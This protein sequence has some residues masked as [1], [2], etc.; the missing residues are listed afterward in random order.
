MHTPPLFSASSL[1]KAVGLLQEN[2]V[3]VY[4]NGYYSVAPEAANILV[5]EAVNLAA[6]TIDYEFYDIKPAV[7][8]EAAER[9]AGNG[10]YVY[11]DMDDDENTVW[12]MYHR[13]VG[14]IGFHDPYG[15]IT[16]LIDGKKVDYAPAFEWSGI[17][18]QDQAFDLL[19]DPDL[20]AKM[21]EHTKPEF[22]TPLIEEQL[23][24]VQKFGDDLS[25]MT[26]MDAMD[27]PTRQGFMAMVER[28]RSDKVAPTQSTQLPDEAGGS[29]VTAVSRGKKGMT[30]GA[31]PVTIF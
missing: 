11:R 16:L 3:E 1:Q 9:G 30:Q 21:A 27:E 19:K 6:K 14:A 20:V 7:F 18:R 4:G 5:A 17:Y 2:G 10:V 23:K 13:D 31:K 12:R 22:M 8:V 26:I 24:E 28:Q 29:W 25:P 15:E